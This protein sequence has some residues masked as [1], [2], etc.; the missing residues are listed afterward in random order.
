MPGP[1]SQHLKEGLLNHYFGATTLT[2]PATLYVA[3]TVSG[4]EVSGSNYA[5]AAVTNNTTNF[6]SATTAAGTTTKTNGTTITFPTPS[7][8]WGTPDGVRVY[9]ASSG[10]NL[11]ATPSLTASFGAVVA[12]NIVAIPASA[13][14][15]D[16]VDPS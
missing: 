14:T 1:L 10:G 15:F 3:L 13:L 16:L 12:G 8:S 5:R 4:V 2:P 11:V 6:P 7:G 9:D